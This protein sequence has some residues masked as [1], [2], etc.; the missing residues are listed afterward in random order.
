MKKVKIPKKKIKWFWAHRRNTSLHHMS[1]FAAGLRNN[2]WFPAVDFSFD[3]Q[4]FVGV[5]AKGVYIFYDK[6]Q[7]NSKYK[8]KDI[9][10]SIDSNPDFVKDFKR[11]T[12]ELFGVIFFKCSLIEKSNLKI[13]SKED[14][15]QLYQEF[16]KAISVAP[17]ITV[18]L[19]GIEACWEENYKIIRF[20]RKKLKGVSQDDKLNEYKEI[21]SVNTGETVAFTEQKD[22]YKVASALHKNKK[23]V[24][25]FKNNGLGAI[26]KKLANYQ[27]ECRLLEK[28]IQKYQWMNIEYISGGW[29][30]E[31]WLSLFKTA[32]LDETSPA[33]QLRRITD[34]F[35]LLNRKRDKLIKKLNL[36]KDVKHALDGLA[37]FIAQRD[38]SKGYFAK[39]LLSYGKLLTEIA[40]RMR[41]KY[42]DLLHYPYEEVFDYFEKSKKINKVELVKRKKYGFVLVIKEGRSKIIT[43]KSNIQKV[44]KK[45]GISDP[46]KKRSG[47]KLLSGLGVSLG[48]TIGRARV[49]E[50]ASK[51]SEFKKGEVLIT[52][53]TTMEFT[54]VFRKA[55]AIVTDEGG[56]SSHAA[57]VSREFKLPCIVGT[58]IA[59]KVLKDG[60]KVEV[61]ANKG[62]V[63]KLVML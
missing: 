42:E 55:R 50:D 17:I 23:V 2:G 27:K 21:L 47:I 7:L 39:A 11:Q 31:K 40:R 14:L 5:P 60:D 59:T 61:D 48:K 41:L 52:Y 32:L 37:E 13:V 38:W 43:G 63:R 30:K 8:Y 62:I 26:H 58:K 1:F 28:H 34:N 6:N 29:P 33:K 44:I 20:L 45:E 35:L 46:F 19:W 16:L 49:L 3:N 10:D 57:I 36:P 18:Q 22:F 15:C 9:Q 54:P 51:I 56:M 4:I 24:N 53:M 25:L 12:N